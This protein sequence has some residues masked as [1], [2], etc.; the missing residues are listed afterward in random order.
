[1]VKDYMNEKVT[2][3]KN[4]MNSVRAVEAGLEV[5]IYEAVKAKTRPRPGELPDYSKIA[6]NAELQ[7]DISTA[8][9]KAYSFDN[10][11]NPLHDVINQQNLGR[12]FYNQ[13]LLEGLLFPHKNAVKAK[14]TDDKFMDVLYANR[15]HS[16][17]AL[18]QQLLGTAA[19]ETVAEHSLDQLKQH[20]TAT[21]GNS[22]QTELNAVN[23]KDKLL[24]AIALDYMKLLG[25]DVNAEQIK[26]AILNPSG[27][28]R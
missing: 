28:Q 7:A 1:M 14:L 21:Y 6:T 16:Q 10:P 11:L 2:G 19:N 26:E 17:K 9:D 23:E 3:L 12:N 5:K 25:A 27:R 8:M 22:F 18:Q 13:C 4:Y 24:R 20:L 15:D